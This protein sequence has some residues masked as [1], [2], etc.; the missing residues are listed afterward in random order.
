MSKEEQARVRDELLQ[1]LYRSVLRCTL[2]RAEEGAPGR[3][4]DLDALAAGVG[5][6]LE[7]RDLLLVPAR[8]AGSFRVL[9]GLPYAGSPGAQRRDREMGVLLLPR[10]EASAVAFALGAA[11]ALG[12]VDPQ[13]S[14]RSVAAVLLPSTLSLTPEAGAAAAPSSWSEAAAFAAQW[15]LPLLFL[16]RHASVRPEKAGETPAHLRPAPPYPA[17]PVDADDPLAIYRVAHECAVRARVPDGGPSHIEAVPFRMR[18]QAG[19]GDALE[20]LEAA[21]RRRGAFTAG[22]R[23]RVER[24]SVAELTR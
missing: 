12:R 6:A 10:N 5:A 15:R 16:S 4:A 20:R 3:E 11:A 21:L 8:G 22:W 2:A 18:G 14:M 1:E 24:A 7:E 13:S 23:R 17:I 9:R 19:E